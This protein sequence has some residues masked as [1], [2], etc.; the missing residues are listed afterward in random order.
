MTEA[1]GLPA[2]LVISPEREEQRC[3]VEELHR[4][5]FGGPLEAAVVARIRQ[6]PHFMPDLSL[7]AQRAEQVVGHVLFSR[8]QLRDAEGTLH[9]AVVLAPLAVRAEWSG[10]GIGSALVH[11]GLARLREMGET[12]VLVRG[13]ASYYQRLGFVSADREQIAPPPPL[14]QNEYSAMRLAPPLCS[15]STIV[16]P[17]SFEVLGYPVE[18]A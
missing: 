18:S 1:A 15:P 3:A 16:Y 9:P 12:L 13:K 14:P 11:T 6:S 2:G 8:V 4:L 17:P 7:V 5:A 10:L